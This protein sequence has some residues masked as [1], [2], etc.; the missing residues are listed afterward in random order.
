ML[1]KRTQSLKIFIWIFK[2]SVNFFKTENKMI[3]ERKVFFKT[4]EGL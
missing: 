1:L 2:K 3:N 4:S